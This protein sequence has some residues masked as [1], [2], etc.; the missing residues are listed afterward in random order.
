MIVRAV[1]RATAWR[2]CSIRRTKEPNFSE[3]QTQMGI[4]GLTKTAEGENDT[5]GKVVLIVKCTRFIHSSP[6]Y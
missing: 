1:R 2:F 5:H 6:W 4:I 3:K